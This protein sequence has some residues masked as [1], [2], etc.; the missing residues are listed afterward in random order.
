MKVGME[1]IEGKQKKQRKVG[2]SNEFGVT[3]R[4]RELEAKTIVVT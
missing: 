3:E 4:Q 2:K 1:V